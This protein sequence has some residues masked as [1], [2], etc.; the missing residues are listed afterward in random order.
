MRKFYFLLMLAGV[1]CGAGYPWYFENM[2]GQSIGSYPA[3]RRA[4][5]FQPIN[6]ILTPDQNPVRVFVDMTPVS[7][8]YPVLTRTMLTLTASTS[9]KTVFAS[10]LDFVSTSKQSENLQTTE[11]IFRDQAGDMMVVQPGEYTFVVGEGDVEGLSMKSVNLVLRANAQDPDPRVQPV[12]IA[13]FLL[14]LFGFIRSLRR[15]DRPETTAT[16]EVKAPEKS[17]WGRDAADE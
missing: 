5:G 17:K 2:S 13:L 16:E 11:K 12:G 1:V 8:Y 4:T 7:G 10:T 15:A 14:G 3:Y 6:V 9:G